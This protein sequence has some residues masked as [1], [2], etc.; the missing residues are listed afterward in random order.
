M[1]NN[2][3]LGALNR[4]IDSL[5]VADVPFQMVQLVLELQGIE[6]IGGCLGRQGQPGDFGS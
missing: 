4:P 6:K 3:G 1:Q 2:L 5:T